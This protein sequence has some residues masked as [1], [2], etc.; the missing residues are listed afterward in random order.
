[1]F[2][3]EH[4][5]KLSDS[6]K[7]EAN[8]AKRQDVRNKISIANKGKSS[9]NKGKSLSEEIKK[10]MRIAAIGRIPWNKGVPMTDE[11]KLKLSISL[12]GRKLSSSHIENIKKA[13][14]ANHPFKGH[15]HTEETKEKLRQAALKQFGKK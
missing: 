3:E 4:K 5:K 12:S 9:W 6:K 7:G 14:N 15:H 8:P 2:S 1:M 11:Q 13:V 10:K